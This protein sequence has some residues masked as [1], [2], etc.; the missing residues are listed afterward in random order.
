MI[1]S[2]NHPTGAAKIA[3]QNPWLFPCGVPERPRGAPYHPP[4]STSTSWLG[5]LAS[6]RRASWKT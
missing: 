4:S 1:M 3:R 2:F 6:T 5:V